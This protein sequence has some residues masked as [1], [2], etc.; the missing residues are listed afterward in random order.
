[1]S[2]VNDNDTTVTQHNSEPVRSRKTTINKRN[3]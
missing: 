1:M 3:P 2:P